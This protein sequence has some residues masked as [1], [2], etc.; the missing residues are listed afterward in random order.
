MCPQILNTIGLISGIIGTIFVFK[1]GLPPARES[2]NI[3]LSDKTSV[4]YNRK[5]TTLP[6][7]EAEAAEDR[8]MTRCKRLSRTG[9]ALIA[10]GFGLQ[11]VAVWLPSLCSPAGNITRGRSSLSDCAALILPSMGP[12]GR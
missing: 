9:L 11:L 7:E 10:I 3:A 4:R 1:W 5:D 2:F 6:K 8:Y 12:P